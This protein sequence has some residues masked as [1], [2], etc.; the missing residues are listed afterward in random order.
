MTLTLKQG[1]DTVER[2]NKFR[3]ETRI[4][5]AEDQKIDIITRMKSVF[6]PYGKKKKHHNDFD[7]WTRCDY[8]KDL[9]MK[10]WTT[11]LSNSQQHWKFIAILFLKQ[12]W[13]D[14][15][16][17]LVSAWCCCGCNHMFIVLCLRINKGTTHETLSLIRTVTTKIWNQVFS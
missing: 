6:V 11:Y 2:V 9:Q 12:N 8:V 4:S 15:P 17:S 10:N 7:K 14:F 13:M 1:G 5:D 3:K 16:Y